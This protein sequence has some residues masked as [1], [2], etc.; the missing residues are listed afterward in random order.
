M[1]VKSIK[2]IDIG[3]KRLFFRFDFNVPLDESGAVRDETRIERAL[4]TLRYAVEKGA[5]CILSSHLGR[6][7]GKRVLELSLLPVAGALSKLLGTPVGFVD[8]CIGPDVGAA[9]A[10]LPAGGLLLLENLR[11]HEGETKNDPAFSKELAASADVY[12]NDAFGTAHRAHASTVGITEFVEEKGAGLLMKEELDNLEK[13]FAAPQHPVLALFGGAKVSDKLGVLRNLLDRID[14]IAI[15]GGMANTF[16]KAQGFSMGTSRVEEDMISMAAEILDS[17]QRKKRVILL[18]LDLVTAGAMEPQAQTTIVEASY[19]PDDKMALDIGPKTS[20]LFRKAVR[21]A[22]T[23]VWNGPMG[24]FEMGPFKL[25]TQTVAR[26]IAASKAFSV[27]GGGDTVRAARQF[28]VEDRIS[29]ISTGG[30]AFM[31]FME[32]KVLPGVAALDR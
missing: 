9:V 22:A 15:G 23:I 18:P 2:D 26:E 24:V 7:K 29:Y 20:E 10:A 27:A 5:R 17:A 13:A 30:G 8:D 4:P 31:E 6:P 19:V 11:F 32:G 1:A 12:I 28:G 14:V 16:L 3:G 21:E 25:G